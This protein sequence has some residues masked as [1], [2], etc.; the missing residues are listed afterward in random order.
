MLH[1]QLRTRIFVLS[2]VLSVAG[3]AVGAEAATGTALSAIIVLLSYMIA[4][5]V[6]VTQIRQMPESDG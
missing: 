4:L 2:L 6:L 5:Y 3:S 1:L